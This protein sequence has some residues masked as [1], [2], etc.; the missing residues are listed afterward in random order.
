MNPP[1]VLSDDLGLAIAAKPDTG[2]KLPRIHWES[3]ES[4]RQKMRRLQ[5]DR[6]LVLRIS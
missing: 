3:E 6:Q 2:S 1:Q 5:S 4:G